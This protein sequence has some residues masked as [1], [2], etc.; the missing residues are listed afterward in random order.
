[1]NE[2]I[3]E[4][5]EQLKEEKNAIILAHNY[6]PNEIQEIAD[7]IGD[8]LELCIKASELENKDL[9]IFC[10]VDFMA[11][12]A[13][14]LNPNKKIVLPDLEAECPMA[15]MLNEKELTEAI[16]KHPDA[17][18][19]LYVNS[20]AESKQAATI[21]CTSA[22]AL[23]VVES[24]DQ[25]IILFGPDSN[26]GKHVAEKTSKKIIPVPSDG[27]CYVHKKFTVEDINLKRAEYPNADVICHPECNIE[28]Q[29]ASDAVLSTGGMLS[30]IGK[31]NKE[32]FIMGTEVD[33]L[34]RIKAN[35][36]NKKVYPLRDDAICENMKVHTIE[37]V[38]DALKNE[39]PE[40]K[41]D[42]KICEKSLEAVKRML[43]VSN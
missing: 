32:E 38:R 11:E 34:N 31:S 29:E 30:Y 8:S 9:I 24:L 21:L 43:S 17:G 22:N 6:Q 15:H 27:H 19:C 40:I 37:K 5:I 13:Y 18:I 42:K 7:F 3:K 10:G 2:K 16:E 1:M 41:L 35:F 36:P 14:I 39:A 12:T 28:V 4:E 33:M 25:D 23:K 26:L 20:L